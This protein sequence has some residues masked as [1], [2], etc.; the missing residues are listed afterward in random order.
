MNEDKILTLI[1]FSSRANKFAFGK[2]GLRSYISK[3][4]KHK[5]VVIASD[6]SKNTLKDLMNKCSHYG[7]KYVL[8]ESKNKLDLAKAVGKI[9]VSAVGIEDESIIKGIIDLVN[10]GDN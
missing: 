8:L 6:A 1:G 3:P 10:G 9:E 5:L 2:E 4:R 7:I